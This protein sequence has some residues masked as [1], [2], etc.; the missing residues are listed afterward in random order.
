[1]PA[2]GTPFSLSALQADNTACTAPN[3]SIAIT[4]SPPGNY[5]FIWSNGF[6]TEDLANLSSG[7]YTVT[8]TDSN[9]CTTTASFNIGDQVIIP[10]VSGMTKPSTCGNSNG[11]IDITVN[12]PG[13]YSFLWS[14]GS[15]QEDLQNIQSG[16]YDVTVTRDNG[17]TASTFFNV[18]DTS[19]SFSASA[20]LSPHT[21]CL[22]ANGAIDLTVSPAGTYQFSWSNGASTEDVLFI[23]PGIYS[24]TV[25]DG[26]NCSIVSSF[27]IEDSVVD[28]IVEEIII[29]T[30]CGE[31]NG[32]IDLK[33]TPP[34]GNSFIWSNGNTTEDLVNI[35]P[36][37]YTVTVTGQNGCEWVSGYEMTGS[38]GLEIEIGVNTASGGNG[39]VTISVQLNVPPGALDTLIW[40]PESLFTCDQPFCLEQTIIK[41]SSRTEI[42][43][44]A[45]DTN[46]CTAQA[47]LLFEDIS[48]PKVF[49]PNV[50]SPNGD[51]VNDLFTVYGNEDVEEVIE[52]QIFDRWGNF[53]FHNDHFPPNEENYGWD[54]RFK[55]SDMNP[56]VFAF[57][58]K[59]R[60]KD[61]TE[62]SYKGDVTLVR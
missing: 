29:P 60:Y 58:A 56:A 42:T 46:G 28:L 48:N 12:P 21:S 6:F 61:G 51:G 53:V 11:Q 35:P 24:V 22:G 57:W 19:S 31:A 15:T 5:N 8:V 23:Q 45:I 26:S 50:F 14:N 13:I 4:I 1:V 52:L 16:F 33:V 17:C 25:T 10:A 47:F 54:G 59:V 62:G 7:V 32:G 30:R 9:G 2:L 41:P 18:Q 3:G 36:G 55:N 39:L 43:V 38:D 37:L 40:L 49:I 34:G 20:I 27:T 44:T